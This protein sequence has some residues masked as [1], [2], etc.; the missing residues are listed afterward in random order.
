VGGVAAQAYRLYFNAATRE[1]TRLFHGL[2]PDF[3]AARAAIPAQRMES[4]DNEPSAYRMI[5]E[6]LN[7]DASDYPVMF[8]LAKVLPGSRLVFDWGGNTGLKYFAYRKFVA[9]SDDLTWL[10]NDVP[11]VVA[12]GRQVAEREAAPA[13]RFTTSLDALA[14]ADI[15]LASGVLQ[16]I[17]HPLTLVTQAPALPRQLIISK[18]PAY[19]L[20]PAVTLHNMGTA[21]CPYHLF[22]HAEL[23]ATFNRLGFTLVDSWQSPNVGC[24]IPFHPEHSIDAYTGYYFTRAD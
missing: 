17:E 23:I 3:A 5:D 8:W 4:Y 15:L 2:Y 14:D 24:E 20:A 16:F 21:L 12:F 6:W 22:N 10:V 7:I 9:F 19:G 18:V 11:A 13:L 1:H